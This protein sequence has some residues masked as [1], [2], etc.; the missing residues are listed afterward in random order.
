MK[1]LVKRWE[2]VVLGMRDGQYRWSVACDGDFVAEAV[3]E[4]VARDI[5]WGMNTVTESVLAER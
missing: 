3:S 4:E 5:A 2:A 1:K